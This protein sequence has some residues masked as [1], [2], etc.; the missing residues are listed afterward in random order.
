MI[1]RLS[2][3]PIWVRDQDTAKDFYVDR[4]GFDVR[5]DVTMDGFRWLTV[6]PKGQ[7]DVELILI[8]PGPPMHDE[9]SAAEI[10][11]LVAKGAF[12]GGVMDTSDCRTTFEDLSARGVTFLQEPADRPYGV[13]G[14]FRDDS[15][16]WFSLRQPRG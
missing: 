7:P 16:N 14:V 3:T 15:G 4:L 1:D 12:S 6:A 8:K 11:A 10:L 5:T 9:Q 2:H 13:E